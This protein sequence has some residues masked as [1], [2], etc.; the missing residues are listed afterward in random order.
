MIELR[1]QEI[2][3]SSLL[4]L[5][6]ADYKAK[7]F[8]LTN[9]SFVV[10]SGD[11]VTDLKE[12]PES[13]LYIPIVGLI[14]PL[15]MVL[16]EELYVPTLDHDYYYA[17]KNLAKVFKNLYPHAPINKFDI[18]VNVL[19]R[20]HVKSSKT[21]I[22]F[23]GGVDS[24]FLLFKHLDKKPCLIFILG[25]DIPVTDVEKWKLPSKYVIYI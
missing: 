16:G 23:S 12:L 7:P 3:K 8:L 2:K 10:Y 20:N 15:A 19:E 4:F 1:T 17:L 24:T 14:A 25:S 5:I 11:D 9:K 18:E 21:C 6:R 13:V 22:L